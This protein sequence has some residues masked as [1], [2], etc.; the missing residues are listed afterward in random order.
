[1]NDR[2]IDYWRP[3][4]EVFDPK[5]E[6]GQEG[7]PAALYVP[8]PDSP[9]AQ[10]ERQL[11]L[12]P[13]DPRA[14]TL[15]GHRG[16]GKSSE[17]AQLA[18][19]LSDDFTVLWLDAGARFD[20]HRGGQTELFLALAA[21]I[22]HRLPV[23]NEFGAMAERLATVT[24]ETLGER[25]ASLV[26]NAVKTLG[27]EGKISLFD[28]KD[29]QLVEIPPILG[30]L[31]DG[32]NQIIA[33]AAVQAIGKPLALIVDG[34]DLLDLESARPIFTNNRL[35]AELRCHLLLAIPF[36]LYASAAQ[37]EARQQGFLAYLL[38]NVKLR[39]RQQAE[40]DPASAGFQLM[41]EVIAR[42]LAQVH[43]P[44]RLEPAAVRPLIEMSG[45]VMRE[46]ISLVNRGC[47]QASLTENERITANIAEAV[48]ADYRREKS[49]GLP[50]DY[51][52]EEL[53]KVHATG[54][55]TDRREKDEQGQE[56][57]VCDRL[58]HTLY[59][60]GYENR[61]RWF[62]VHPIVW[63]LVEDYLKRTERGLLTP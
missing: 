37:A 55:L 2:W 12:Y 57:V 10:I 59:I 22:H 15:T 24:R 5:K 25:S 18:R 40:L 27:V 60:L 56:F 19:S 6:P 47:V 11:R 14:I 33:A 36:P 4:V 43:T 28:R 45:G 38:P 7:T 54:Q 26:L 16:S 34:T 61:K 50:Y 3:V 52:Y 42:R 49:W 13:N 63:E 44:D 32:L 29:R 51:F 62:D 30:G 31:V 58:L 46:L 17:L 9:L 48:I 41:E 1:M 53:A 21:T 39:D 35:L 23:P 8:R 20:T